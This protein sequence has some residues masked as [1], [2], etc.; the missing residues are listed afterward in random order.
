MGDTQ[1]YWNQCFSQIN[2]NNEAITEKMSMA[3]A[4]QDLHILKALGA[5]TV[6]FG[7]P[8]SAQEEQCLKDK[9]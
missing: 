9:V 3:I 4:F 6:I 1:I 7:D 5:F 2:S 8:S